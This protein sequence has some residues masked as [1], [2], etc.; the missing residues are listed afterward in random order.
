[1]RGPG[2]AS[3]ASASKVKINIKRRRKEGPKEEIVGCGMVVTTHKLEPS[4][5]SEEL[6]STEITA[7][8]IGPIN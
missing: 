3:F 7:G 8:H 5:V 1:M 6:N 2:L 4:Q